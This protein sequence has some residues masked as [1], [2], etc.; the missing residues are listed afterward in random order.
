MSRPKWL[1][2][3]ELEPRRGTCKAYSTLNRSTASKN[4]V[5]LVMLKGYLD[6]IGSGIAWTHNHQLEASPQCPPSS[7]QASDNPTVCSG[8]WRR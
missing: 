2:L 8:V 5:K 1:V 6:V 4:L 7:P 3:A